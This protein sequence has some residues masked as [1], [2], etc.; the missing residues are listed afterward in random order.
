MDTISQTRCHDK[1]SAE[2]LVGLD[3]ICTY[4]RASKDQ[5]HRWHRRYDFP[6]WCDGNVWRAS[7]TAID[8]WWIK[9]P[10]EI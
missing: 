6:M 3:E 1:Q 9:G 5:V 7:R 8:E 10:Q 2:A 4:T